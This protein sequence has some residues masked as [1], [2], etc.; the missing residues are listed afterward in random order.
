MNEKSSQ[1]IK[2]KR[3]KDS[4]K[5]SIIAQAIMNL[6]HDSANILKNNDKIIL[7]EFF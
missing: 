5:L 4:K 2:R 7:V 6:C 3:N 1:L